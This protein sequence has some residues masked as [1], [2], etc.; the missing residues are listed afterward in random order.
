MRACSRWIEGAIVGSA[1]C[2]LAPHAWSQEPRPRGPREEPP[3]PISG[4]PPTAPSPAPP[5]AAYPLEMLG[6]LAP[7]GPRAPFTL[8][9]SIAVSEE[10]NDNLF[11]DNRNRQWELITGFSPVITLSVSRPSYQLSG[12]YSFTAELYERESRFNNAFERQN[13]IA[14]GS[15]QPTQ[16]LT[17]TVADSFALDRSTNRVATQSFATGRQESW[18]NTFSPG[19]RW[20]MTPRTSLALS[21][22][23]GILR[24]KGATAEGA[25]AGID[26][27]TYGAQSTLD[28]VLTPRL[29]STFGYGFTYLDL[30]GDE[31][32]R[33]HTPTLGF[34]YRLTPTLTGSISGGPSITEIG[35]E[36]LMSPSGAASLS[37][38]LRFGSVS[39]QYTR[40]VAVAGGL[41]GT[42]DTQTASGTLTL[43][44]LWR[45]LF[46]V[47]TPA[48]SIAE[49]LSRAQTERVDVRALTVNLGLT[50]QIARYASVF[51]GYTLL[52]QRTGGASSVGVDADQN[53]V[54]VGLQFGYPINFD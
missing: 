28:H 48:Y 14:N 24:F 17:F 25:D 18:S 23:Y 42:T 34:S 27:D 54:R 52:Q 39:V 43:P 26:S 44:A 1:I 13:F 15:Y 30:R 41:G 40:A 16:Q 31:N 11:L 19:M 3:A 6:L 33:T 7:S 21:A 12:G 49:S 22:S 9:P 37:Q 46:V 32:S 20:Q 2:L 5:V 53:R 51:G 35:G 38:A 29:T 36:T 8:T 10:Y 45:D 47:I 50:Y 4:P